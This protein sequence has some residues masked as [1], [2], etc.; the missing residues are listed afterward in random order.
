MADSLDFPEDEADAAGTRA[1]AL[2]LV[3]MVGLKSMEKK[4]HYM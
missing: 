1:E 4:G 3:D 2:A